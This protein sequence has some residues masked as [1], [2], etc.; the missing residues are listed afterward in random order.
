MT[1]LRTARVLTNWG[2]YGPLFRSMDATESMGQPLEYEVDPRALRSFLPT[3]TTAEALEFLG[4]INRFVMEASEPAVALTYS[5]RPG[6]LMRA[7]SV[8]L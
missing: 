4:P 2:D 7:D 5:T 8:V 1:L 3:C 6:E